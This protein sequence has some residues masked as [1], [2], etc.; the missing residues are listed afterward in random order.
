MIAIAA[1]IVAA[2]FTGAAL[3][4]NVAEHPARMKLDD[5]N[6][7]AQWKPAYKRGFAMQASLAIVGSLFGAYVAWSSQLS[8]WWAGALVLFANWPYTLLAIRPVNK[9]LMAMERPGENARALMRDWNMLHAGRTILGAFA[10]F[11]FAIGLLYL[12]LALTG[13]GEVRPTTPA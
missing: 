4:I 1:L 6:A 2:L 8:Y 7:L 12:L 3:Y 9:K 10:T 13:G 5:A 11:L